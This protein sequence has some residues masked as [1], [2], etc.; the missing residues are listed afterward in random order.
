VAVYQAKRGGRNRVCLFG[1]DNPEES[2]H[3]NSP[4]A[5]RPETSADV[6]PMTD[7]YRVEACTA[8]NV[9]RLNPSGKY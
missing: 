4:H 6:P 5:P 8:T 9:L 3:T 7:D 2:G 1:Q